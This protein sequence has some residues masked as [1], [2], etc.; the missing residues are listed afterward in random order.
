M[1]VQSGEDTNYTHSKVKIL[2]MVIAS[3]T[4]TII[5]YTPQ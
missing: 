1:S 3:C 5:N 2:W 4:S